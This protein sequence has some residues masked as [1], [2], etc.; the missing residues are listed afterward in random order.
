[1]FNDT[2]SRGLVSLQFLSALNNFFG[3]RIDLSRDPITDLYYNLSFEAL[4][5]QQNL[6]LEKISDLNADIRF[7][8]SIL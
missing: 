2:K 1:M 5:G 6:S 7:S 8:M 4:S 3:S